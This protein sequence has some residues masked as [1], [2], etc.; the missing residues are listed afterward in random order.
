MQWYT[1]R[2]HR[3]V[4]HDPVVAREF[5]RAMNMVAPPTALAGVA[6]R[7]LRGGGERTQRSSTP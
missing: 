1:A 7:V 5:Y 4:L 3:A 2:V 6:W